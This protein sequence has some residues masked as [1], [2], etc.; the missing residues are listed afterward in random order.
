MNNTIYYDPSF[1]DAQRRQLLFEGQLF[2]YAPRRS[3]LALVEFSR[4]LIEEAFGTLDPEMAQHQ[5]SV[6]QYAAILL[7]L[8]QGFIHHPESKRL[9]QDIFVEMG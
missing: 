4:T 5:L 7:K 1:S 2:V 9:I 6:E 8:K 3:T